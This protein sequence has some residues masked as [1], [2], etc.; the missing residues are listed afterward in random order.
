VGGLARGDGGQRVPVPP[1]ERSGAV[2]V[3]GRTRSPRLDVWHGSLPPPAAS[4]RG[5]RG[6]GWDRRRVGVRVACG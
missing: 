6:L 5:L 2:P 1:V 3:V 4:P